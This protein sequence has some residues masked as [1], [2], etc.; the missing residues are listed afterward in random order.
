[1]AD[2]RKSQLELT[3][4]GL[5]LQASH[6]FD[7]ANKLKET[8]FFHI[9]EKTELQAFELEKAIAQLRALESEPP[10]EMI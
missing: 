4:R 7:L 10:Q 2:S 1:M 6:L 9:A 8:G 5:E 3:I